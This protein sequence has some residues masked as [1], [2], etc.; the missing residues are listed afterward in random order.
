MTGL[1]IRLFVKNHT[2]TADPDVRENYGKF[3]G[4]VGIVCNLFLCLVKI[5]V[6]L[7]AGGISMVA[8]GLNN[9]SD[10]G[11]SVITMI[12]FK[13]AGK[14]ADEDH[15]FGHGRM[16]YLSAFI[17][18]G[19]I[20]VVGFELLTSSVKTLLL[21]EP[22][23]KY[24]SL[25]LL[26]LGLSIPVKLWMFLFNRKLGRLIDSGSLAATAQDCIN[27]SIASFAILASAVVT[28]FVELPFSLDALMACGVA[29]FILWSGIQ[30]ARETL[31]VILGRPPEAELVH[32]IADTVLSFEDFVGIHDLMVHDYGA[33]RQFASVHVEVPQDIDIVHCH[34]QVDLCEKLVFEKMGVQLVIHMD[35][36][37]VNDENI[38]RVRQKMIEAIRKIDAR[39]S[40]HDFRMTPAAQTRTNL[41]FDVVLPS[42]LFARQDEIKIQIREAAKQMDTTYCCVITFDMDYTGAH[43]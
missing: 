27:D 43:V 10:M 31:N 28:R 36:I 7:V 15:P 8:D 14:P 38:A 24:S 3:G 1:L 6:G 41:I 5:T 30:T 11:S 2:A 40:L 37:D 18:S 4:F 17:V 22:S 23:P 39:L 33:G 32:E 42:D 13:M 35:P 21:F 20:L 19:L 26:M 34:E 29:L 12:G 9:L 25:A 16:E